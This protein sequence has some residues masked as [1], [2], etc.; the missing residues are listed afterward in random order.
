MLIEYCIL[1]ET[2][3]R[4]RLI[5]PGLVLSV[6]WLGGGEGQGML[7]RHAFE[8][9]L[10]RLFA[11]VACLGWA[12]VL[13]TFWRGGGDGKGMSPRHCFGNGLGDLLQV[14]AERLGP[15]PV[16]VLAWGW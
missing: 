1:W 13:S 11:S 16:D 4:C 6:F 10:G 5:R 15:R 9:G 12:N 8:D 2:F 7:P 14:S 3:S